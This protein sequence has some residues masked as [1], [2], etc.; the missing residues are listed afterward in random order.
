MRTN[1]KHIVKK[2]CTF[3][4][5]YF[6]T[7]FPLASAAQGFTKDVQ[8][9][10]A[11]SGTVT[12][13]HDAAIDDLVNGSSATRKQ[14][15]AKPASTTGTTGTTSSAGSASSTKTNGNATAT[16]P[17]DVKDKEQKSQQKDDKAKEQ[18][19][20]QKDDKGK[21]QKC[22]EQKLKEEKPKE[23]KNKEEKAKDDKAAEDKS[24]EE[25]GHEK[26]D[27]G[28]HEQTTDSTKINTEVNLHRR[29]YKVDGYRIQVFAG[30]N[31]RNDRQK[32][33]SIGRRL[34]NLFPEDAVYVHFYSPRWICRMG[35]FRNYGEARQRLVEVRKQGYKS[36]TIV[37]GKIIVYQ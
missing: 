35:N 24:H 36:A 10:E 32:A 18:K 20:Q 8:K 19:S 30:G 3:L 23:E 4:P 9:K 16:T 33:E 17:K 1:D 25:K 27:S 29:S 37:K 22:N 7:L 34:E 13:H 28:R 31:T 14:Q 2:V 12:I 5:F 26:E 11:S 21:E 6:F 15:P